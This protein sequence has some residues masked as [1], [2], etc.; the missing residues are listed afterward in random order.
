LFTG[1]LLVQPLHI[2]ADYPIWN[3]ND[4]TAQHLSDH[5]PVVIVIGFE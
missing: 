4:P 2:G 1:L 3:L 5:D